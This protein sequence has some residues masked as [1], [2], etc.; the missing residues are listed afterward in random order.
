ML[1]RDIL[2]A[3]RSPMHSSVSQAHAKSV[4]R[5]RGEGGEGGGGDMSVCVLEWAGRGG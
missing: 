4:R 3:K 5:G 2:H 1:W